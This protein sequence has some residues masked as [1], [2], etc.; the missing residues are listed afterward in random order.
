[1]RNAAK[2]FL[3][4]YLKKENNS[5][6]SQA[7]DVTTRLHANTGSTL[8]LSQARED[9]KWVG[10]NHLR[11]L[12]SLVGEFQLLVRGTITYN[13]GQDVVWRDHMTW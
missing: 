9:R 1:M 11:Q 12:S 2:T 3:D 7:P 8:Y 6:P 5:T 13:K 4:K 10:T